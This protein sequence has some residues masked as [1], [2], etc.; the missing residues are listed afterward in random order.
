[1]DMRICASYV[2]HL[3]QLRVVHSQVHLCPPMPNGPCRVASCLKSEDENWIIY[4]EQKGSCVPIKWCQ[5]IST[6][7]KSH[8]HTSE[9]FFS[10]DG[11]PL[12]TQNVKKCPYPKSAFFMYIYC[13]MYLYIQI[14]IYVCVCVSSWN[15]QGT[16]Q[17]HRCLFGWQHFALFHHCTTKECRRIHWKW[18]LKMKAPQLQKSRNMGS[19]LG[20][21]TRDVDFDFGGLSF[22][23]VQIPN[24]LKHNHF[25]CIVMLQAFQIFV[26]TVAEQLFLQELQ[27][28]PLWN[29]H[30]LAF[31]Q[32]PR[33]LHFWKDG[34]PACSRFPASSRGDSK[35]IACWSAVTWGEISQTWLPTGCFP[36]IR[37]QTCRFENMQYRSM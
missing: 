27:G 24:T 23:N 9:F 25:T 33:L 34:P 5:A 36:I 1:M 12:S 16:N 13:K 29:L 37:I 28:L 15:A 17:H 18:N 4:D 14:Y 31:L 3:L 2:E 10:P 32:I 7:Q 35:E 21:T 6:L 19:Q 30:D 20:V 8:T 22:R 26:D 11:I